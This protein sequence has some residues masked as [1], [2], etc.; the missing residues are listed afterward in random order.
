MDVIGRPLHCRCL[1]SPVL[2]RAYFFVQ[3]HEGPGCLGT[4]CVC[5]WVVLR[6]EMRWSLSGL[7]SNL[8]ISPHS[9]GRLYSLRI[10]EIENIL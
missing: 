8:Q 10:S 3:A 7:L 5:F 9:M 2:I 1:L 4:G 6:C